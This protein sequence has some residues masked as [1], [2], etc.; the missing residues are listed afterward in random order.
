M[1]NY[2]SFSADSPPIY[3]PKNDPTPANPTQG[4]QNN[5]GLEGLTASPDGKKLYTLMQSAL[6]QDGGQGGSSNRFWSRFFIYDA[7]C[8]PPQLEAEY[9]VHLPQ[10]SDNAT[11]AQSE[12]HYISPTQFFVLARDSARGAGQP[13]STSLYRHAD[14]FGISDATNIVGKYD[15]FNTSIV[16]NITTAALKSDIKPATYCSFLDFNINSELN[17]FGV[18]NGGAQDAGLLNEKWES[19]ALVPVGN[20]KDDE[21][22]LFSLSDNDFRAVDGKPP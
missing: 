16:T 6:R 12:I 22:F 11:A 10:A 4:R 9:V 3:D 18:H 14:I 15:A 17:K 21:Y 7:S 1:L 8:S 13:S 5:Q 2:D 19:L 20:K